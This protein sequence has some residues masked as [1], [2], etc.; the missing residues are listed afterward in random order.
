MHYRN[1]IKDLNLYF[2]FLPANL[3]N[4]KFGNC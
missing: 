2:K 4:R 3:Y 1:K